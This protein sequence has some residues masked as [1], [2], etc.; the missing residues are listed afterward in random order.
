MRATASIGLEVNTRHCAAR[1][2]ERRIL[3]ISRGLC[4]VIEDDQAIRDL[5]KPF[6][7]RELTETANRLSPAGPLTAHGKNPAADRPAI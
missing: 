5:T 7:P 3:L 2:R 1:T 4:P 6:L